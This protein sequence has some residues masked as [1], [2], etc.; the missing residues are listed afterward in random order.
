MAQHSKILTPYISPLPGMR[1]SIAFIPNLP[2]W[3]SVAVARRRMENC[4]PATRQ[5][6]LRQTD[7]GEQPGRG[8]KDQFAA[9]AKQANA[10]HAIHGFGRDASLQP[11]PHA[12]PHRR[13]Q[14]QHQR[15]GQI[16]E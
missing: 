8:V 10:P 16:G 1:A 13:E 7:S 4:P 9:G 5:V 2:A 14:A 6:Q 15:S 3:K 11:H 12:D